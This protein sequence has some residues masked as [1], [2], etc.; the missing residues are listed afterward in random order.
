M[1]KTVTSPIERYPGSVILA[2][3]QTYPQYLAWKAAVTE[4]SQI[5]DTDL[6]F[7]AFL[8]GVCA[9]VEKWELTECEQLTPDTFPATPRLAA[10]GLLGWLI[11]EV[12]K[13][14]TGADTDGLPNE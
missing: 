8:P 11:G 4:A 1:S 14:V 12:N 5:E 9:V 13:I 3:P 2:D 6:K 7:Q 10:I